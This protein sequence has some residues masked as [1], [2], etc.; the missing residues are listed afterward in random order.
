MSEPKNTEPERPKYSPSRYMRERHAD[1]FSDSV[2]EVEYQ[3]D[4]EVLSYHLETLTNQ[5]DE[6]VFENF[7]QCLCEKFI[8]PN[9]RPQTGPV[10]G[11][12]G[13]TDAETFPV[14]SEI[15]A[16]WFVPDNDKAGERKAFAFS[17]KKAWRPKVQSD[18]AAIASTKRDYD[19]II[20]VTNQFVPAKKSADLQ[21][22][23]LKEH[24][25]PV[26]ILDRTWLL[27]R[28][29][30]H[31]SMAIAVEELGVGKGTE[32]QSKKLGPSD[33]RRAAELDALEAKIA[34]GSQYQ[35]QPL[36]L[37]EDAR[38]AALLARGLEHS[39]ADVNG[40]FDRA[41]RLA[42]ENNTRKLEL[43]ISFE[44]AWTSHF[45]YE[46]HL[47]TSELYDD[48]ERLAL[49]SEDAN[50]LERLSN[51]LPLIRMSVVTNSMDVSRGKLKDRTAAL[52]A[53]LEA[54]AAQT[55]RPNNALHAEALLLMT[56]V[57]EKGVEH[58]DDPL[59]DIW[60]SFTDVIR[61]AEGL[62]TF[63]FTSIADALTQV[64][65]FIADSEEFD[66]LFEAITDA[67]VSRSGEGEAATRNVQR[68][69]QKLAKGLPYDAIRWFGRAVSLL[70][71]EEY[72][73]DL[74]NALVGAGF[75]FEEVGLP[76]A[77]R[78]YTLA[79][80]SQEFSS[81]GKSGSIGRLRASV[82][83][84]YFETELKLGRFPQILSAHELEM[85]VRHSQARTE[86]QSRRLDQMRT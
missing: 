65:E 41:L 70:V 85:I 25:I 64:G 38:R 39:S 72:E 6:T 55:N 78:N 12:D 44:W 13:K 51:L 24:G 49:D 19:H 2:A 14:S 40:R 22:E 29:L 27:D 21:D 57:S 54:L 83:S 23:L 63:P 46:D 15:S 16:R 18:V 82:L 53:A 59:K 84:R 33:T 42:R 35:G 47:R 9:I 17:A 26:T 28:I 4:R 20:F 73:D 37:V 81:F 30:K 62:G 11:G 75:A 86:G 66:T 77:A 61:R 31:D 74:I 50:D 56:H 8:A 3:V 10:G 79:A 1:L 69:Y 52:K 36:A 5:K 34:D 76:W 80:V 7:A 68:A 60:V 71:K 32:K 43:T 48:V 67:L 45:W 58:R